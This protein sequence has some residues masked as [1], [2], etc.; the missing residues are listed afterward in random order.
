MKTSNDNLYQATPEVLVLDNRG[1]AVREIRYCRHPDTPQ[2][3]DEQ[4]TRHR[5]NARGYLEESIDPRLYDLQSEVNFCYLSTLTG[6]VLRTKSADAGTTLTLKDIAGRPVW[7]VNALNVVRTW[8]YEPSSKAGLLLSITEQAENEPARV[9]ERFVWSEVSE[10]AKNANLAG[11]CVRHYDPAGLLETNSISL[12]GS[13]LSVS[14]RLLADEQEVNW[15]GE[16]QSV[17]D[18]ALAAEIFTTLSAVDATGAV[19]KETDANGNMSLLTYDVAGLLCSSDIQLKGENKQGIIKS[20]TYS[21][22]GQKICEEHG[23]GVI[24]TYEYEASTQRLI[25]LRTERPADHPLGAKVLQD[26]CYEYDPVGN[27]VKVRDNVQETRFWRNQKIEPVNTYVYDSL[28]QLVST[29]GREMAA[30]TQE[31][32]QLPFALSPLPDDAYTCYSRNYSYDRGGN[33]TQICHSAPATSN[34][35]TRNFT[36]SARSNRAVLSTLTDD[37]SKVEDFFDQAGHQ[38]LLTGGQPLVWTGRGELKQV[39]MVDR[40]SQPDQETYRYDGSSQRVVKC[41]VQQTSDSIKRNKVLYLPGLELRTTEMGKNLKESLNTITIGKAGRAQVRVLHWEQGEPQGIENN[42]VRYSYDNLIGSSSLEVDGTGEII[43]RE[44]YYPYGGTAVSSARSQ[45]EAS[46]KTIRYS[47]KERDATGLYYY[48]WRYYQPWTGRWLSAD[49]AGRVDGLNLFKMVGN[50]PV[51]NSDSNGLQKDGYLYIHY[52]NFDAMHYIAGFN[53]RRFL[54]G[55][56]LYPVLVESEEIKERFLSMRETL[57]SRTEV[58]DEDKPEAN[59]AVIIENYIDGRGIKRIPRERR[60]RAVVNKAVYKA[61][62]NLDIR[63]GGLAR[64]KENDKLYLLGHGT[65]GSD[66]VGTQGN[67]D[68]DMNMKQ[69][70]QHLKQ[71]SLSK[72]L[73][74]MRAVWCESG[75]YRSHLKIEIEPPFGIN[76]PEITNSVVPVQALSKE[77]AEAGYENIKVSGYKG[78]VSIYPLSMTAPTFFKERFAEV[79]EI[80]TTVSIDPPKLH[81]DMTHSDSLRASSLRRTYLNGNRIESSRL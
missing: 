39:T 22:L 81:K 77:L 37:L 76:Q 18:T 61:V 8:Q 74:D 40:E 69:Y 20:L 71:S 14:R 65:G 9:T 13:P 68:L 73:Q 58:L 28:Y 19:L 12:S 44:E 38:L 42:Q 50:N 3:T 21:A 10:S 67:D 49:P 15:Q 51:T 5:F 25:R 62:E 24:T 70:A 64:L 32:N 23:N 48:G 29:T 78:F 55:K 11:T 16:N 75:N 56:T 1:L 36:V 7:S 80:Y 33:L 4:I 63:I 52:H 47:G 41:T 27:L 46:Y 59:R 60:Y 30:N 2:Q 31:C 6:E 43:S 35:Y 54:R 34:N 72:S 17:W 79:T 66:T 57:R 53:A 26:L 45:V